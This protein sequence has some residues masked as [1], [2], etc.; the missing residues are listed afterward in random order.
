M[1]GG[2]FRFGSTLPGGDQSGSP[3][4]CQTLSTLEWN[5]GLC[6]QMFASNRLCF[7]SIIVHVVNILF[8]DK[9]IMVQIYGAGD[10]V[11]K[12]PH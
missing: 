4:H 8:F 10:Q 7:Y 3:T 9:P 11:L 2:D 12:K 6:F 5:I 1:P